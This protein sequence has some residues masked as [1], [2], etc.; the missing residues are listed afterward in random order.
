MLLT[1]SELRP[2]MRPRIGSLRPLLAVHWPE[3]RVKK[4]LRRP[5]VALAIQSDRQSL[6]GTRLVKA[7]SLHCPDRQILGHRICAFNRIG[8]FLDR[9]VAGILLAPCRSSSF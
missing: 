6:D 8:A 1:K 7:G 5:S 4:R 9:L 3:N 2:C